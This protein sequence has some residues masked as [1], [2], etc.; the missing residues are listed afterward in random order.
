MKILSLSLKKSD[1]GLVLRLFSYLNEVTKSEH[2][3]K[4]KF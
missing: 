4:K 3:D 1:E 2:T